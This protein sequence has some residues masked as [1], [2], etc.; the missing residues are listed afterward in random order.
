MSEAIEQLTSAVATWPDRA[1]MLV[2]HDQASYEGAAVLLREIKGLRGGIE[3]TFGPIVAKAHAT[4]REA[5]A[6]RKKHEAPL[7]IAER[8]LKIG[9]GSYAAEQERKAREERARQE[10]AAREGEAKRQAARWGGGARGAPST[11]A[12][13]AG[14]PASA[15]GDRRAAAC[16]GRVGARD[17]GSRGGSDDGA[18]RGGRCRQG[19]AG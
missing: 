5:L 7:E 9:M 14:A 6:Q 4:H 8:S 13:G 1:R 3:A 19:G 18:G 17:V 15:A 11:E 10:L 2:I 16:R 12:R